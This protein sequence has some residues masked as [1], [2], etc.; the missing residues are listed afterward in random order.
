MSILMIYYWV[1]D[2]MPKKKNIIM[3]LKLINNQIKDS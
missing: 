3:I 1:N 2:P